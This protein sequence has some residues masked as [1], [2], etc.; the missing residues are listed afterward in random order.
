MDTVRPALA[1]AIRKLRS[2]GVRLS[3]RRIVK[4]QRLVAAAAVLAGRLEAAPTDLWPLFYALPTQA[5]QLQARD[6]LREL[7]ALAEHPHLHYAVEAATLQPRSRVAR[8]VQA[9]QHCLAT[10]AGTLEGADHDAGAGL[11]AVLREIDAN[12]AGDQLPAD[13]APLREQL[14]A[15]LRVAEALAATQSLQMVDGP[16]QG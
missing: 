15:R 14:R 16:A 5:A 11:E 13:L 6:A 1:E 9:A 7:F 10:P 4:A 12:F 8:L 3:D 2:A